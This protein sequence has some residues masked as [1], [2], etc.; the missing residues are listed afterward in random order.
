MADIDLINRP[1]VVDALAP[2]RD[3][4][5]AGR[6]VGAVLFGAVSIA[7]YA[8]GFVNGSGINKPD[9]DGRKDLCGRLVL[10][11]LA[12]LA[13]GASLYRGKRAAVEDGPLVARDREGLEAALA[14]GRL[15]FKGE[16]IHA[17][18]GLASKAGWYAQ[19]GVFAVPG[20][21]QA[22]ARFDSLDL[23]RGS[24]DDARTILTAGLNWIIAGKTKFQVN[25]ELHRLEAAGREKSGLLAQFQAAF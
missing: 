1:A 12:P 2:G 15:S 10:R 21:V 17:K 23:D 7:E 18:D 13:V 25:Y 14:I 6:D 4:G 16:Y 3:I 24:P 9:E 8:V 19:A 20:K 5:A 11:P 22:V